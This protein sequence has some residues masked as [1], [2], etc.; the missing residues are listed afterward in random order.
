MNNGGTMINRKKS[1]KREGNPVPA[2]VR[3]PQTA[4]N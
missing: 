2:Q 4:I 3:H 1:E